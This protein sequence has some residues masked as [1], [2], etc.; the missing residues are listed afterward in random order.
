[1]RLTY[2]NKPVHTRDTA[3]RV[4]GVSR[5]AKNQNRTRTRVM[6]CAKEQNLNWDCLCTFSGMF[7][8]CSE[9]ISVI[10]MIFGTMAAAA[11]Q[12][13]NIWCQKLNFISLHIRT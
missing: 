7:L 9:F 11:L 10:W 13:V 4:R 6:V 3:V 8:R 1:M 2:H 5:C 12:R